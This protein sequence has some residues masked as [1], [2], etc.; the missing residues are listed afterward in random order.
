MAIPEVI[1]NLAS[2]LE[3]PIPMFP[4]LVILNCSA[5]LVRNTRSL[6][7]VV[8]MNCVA[9]LVPELPV[10]PHHPPDDACQL[11]FPDASV[12][13]TYPVDTPVVR[14]NPVNAP[15]QDTSSLYAGLFVQIPTLEPFHPRM[16]APLWI[17]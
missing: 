9:G 1:W 10:S 15:V 12:V 3:T 14:R 2:G 5:L 16:I 11:A 8:P 7:S 17:D 4:L 13:S 6:A